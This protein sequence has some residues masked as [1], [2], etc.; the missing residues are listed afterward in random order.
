MHQTY[1]VY[2]RIVAKRTNKYE[3]GTVLVRAVRA[4]TFT[5]VSFKTNPHYRFVGRYENVSEKEAVRLG[6]AD[7]NKADQPVA[8]S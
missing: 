4:G 8:V 6:T 3:A 5:D 7:F 2:V 1:K